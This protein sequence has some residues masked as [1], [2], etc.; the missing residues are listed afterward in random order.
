MGVNLFQAETIH[1][2]SQDTDASAL[3]LVAQH[4]RLMNGKVSCRQDS[5]L[6]HI[7]GNVFH[8]VSRTE[9]MQYIV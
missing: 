3:C 2:R 9:R 7:L 8:Q 5:F 6:P 4:R 1:V